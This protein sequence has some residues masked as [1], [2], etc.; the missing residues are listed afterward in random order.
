MNRLL[1]YVALLC[2][3]Q[4]WCSCRA[5]ENLPVSV[6]HSAGPRGRVS[7]SNL[8]YDQPASRP[9]AGQPIGNGR[10]GTMVWTSP[11]AL[12]L[13]IHR[14]DV[15][16]VNRDHAGPR[17]GT[18]DYCGGIARVT[19][20]VG[21]Q[22]F[23]GGDRKFRQELSLENAE[24]VVATADLSI[25]TF[26]CAVADVLV[27]EIDDQ[28]ASPEAIQVSVAML[29]PPEVIT[30]E[31]TATT[32]FVDDPNH[33]VMWQ[34]FREQDHHNTSALH[35][36]L[37]EGEPASV[38]PTSDTMRTLVLPA[39]R[40]RRVVLIASAASREADESTVGEARRVYE[41]AISR[42]VDGL[43]EVH[44][45]WWRSFWSRT[46]VDVSSDDGAAERAQR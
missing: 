21:S 45:Q 8:V 38:E 22:C 6:A 35:V 30:G 4:M 14:N 17:D 18:A 44:R 28:R 3:Q 16:A 15:F 31:H 23:A 12:H 2:V 32:G 41:H 37:A 1:P 20:H 33:L 9:E 27:L 25:H 40:G 19:V 29:R 5:D 11:E 36:G 7:R 13:Q 46:F 10:M 42:S 26:V 34:R 43:R 39:S 24:C